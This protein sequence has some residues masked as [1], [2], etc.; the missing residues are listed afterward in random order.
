M[1]TQKTFS[2][3]IMNPPFKSGGLGRDAIRN[4]IGDS[5]VA[6]SSLCNESPFVSAANNPF[7]LHS[8]T[9]Q[10]YPVSIGQTRNRIGFDPSR[11]IPTALENSVRTISIQYWRRVS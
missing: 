4:F 6:V 2:G 3:D 11:A 1:E 9:Y 10:N 7:F 5:T 8:V